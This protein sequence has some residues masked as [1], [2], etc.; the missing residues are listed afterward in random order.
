MTM[1]PTADTSIIDTAIQSAG[2][3]A[4]EPAVA[5]A[6]EKIPLITSDIGVLAMLMAVL[7]LLFWF[8][9]TKPGGKFFSII[10]MLVFCYFLPT[11]LTTLGIL[12]DASPVYT[13]IKTFLL[14][15]SL[16]L[17][18]LALDLPGIV[19]LGPKAIIMLLAG[20]AGVVV[21][22]PIALLI[23]QNVLPESMALPDDTW[24][25]LT[26]LSGSWIGGGA[27]M[28][29]LGEIAGVTTDMFAL[30]VIVDVAIANIWMGVLLFFAGKAKQIDKI[31]GANTDAIEDLKQRVSKFQEKAARIPTLA[32]Y[33]VMLS[34]AFVGTWLAMRG[35]E[36]LAPIVSI[37]TNDAGEPVPFFSATVWKFIL[38]T[39]LALVLSLT[40][41]RNYDGVGASK[42]GSVFLYILVAS[43]GAHAN[44]ITMFSTPAAA[45]LLAVGAIWML[46][47]I[48]VL[49]TVAIIIK[50]P[51]FF[52]A[53]GSQANIG[54]AA[55]APIVA[56]AFHP[57]LAPVGVLLAVAGYVLG[58]YAGLACMALLKIVA[59]V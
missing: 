3:V 5:E 6:I 58:T 28:V 44:F 54:G 57:S 55:S 12:P 4:S 18:I 39:S 34:I 51:I 27:N 40:K 7:A 32:D 46:I 37:S 20:T 1:T 56:S 26:A 2:A 59:G 24:Q 23:V 22:G 8:N 49:L 11:T 15:A 29:A 30:M 41:I 53:V 33:L 50:A 16:V 45:G 17:L 9:G 13:W 47:H 14:P 48:I 19:K 52:V 42:I 25:G 43:I 35:G 10:P 38:V 21:G 36:W 31:T